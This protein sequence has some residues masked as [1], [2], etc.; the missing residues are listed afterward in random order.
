ME[1]NTRNRI[2]KL[3]IKIRSYRIAILK[4]SENTGY[5]ATLIAD[6]LFLRK[7]SN[8]KLLQKL[9]ECVDNLMKDRAIMYIENEVLDIDKE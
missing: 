6:V 8:D 5:S 7:K 1:E 9:E 3:K 2:K 4:I